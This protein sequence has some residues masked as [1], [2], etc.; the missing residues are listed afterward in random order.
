MD[1]EDLIAVIKGL[2]LRGV[3]GTTGT[4][5]SFMTLF[6]G[7]GEKVKALEK[8]VVKKMG[9]DAA[10]A[11][12][13]QTYTRKLDYNVLSVLSRIAQ[14]AYKFANDL[15]ILQNMKEMEEP[16][17]KNQIGSSAMAY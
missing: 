16:F 4:Q 13:G 10:F 8:Y 14:S 11:V 9:F 7:D 5:A 2:K 12:S 1:Y 17:E 3:K 15:R 6:D